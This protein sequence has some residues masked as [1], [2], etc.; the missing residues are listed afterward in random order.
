VA[1]IVDFPASGTQGWDEWERSIRKVSSERGLTN[2]VIS[3]ALP[4][5]KDHWKAICSEVDLEL[6]ERMIPGELTEEQSIAIQSL[7]D[8]AAAVVIDRLKQERALAVRRLALVEL[9]LSHSRAS[10]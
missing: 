5:I 4:R 9:A 2:E 6:P 8:D 3:H 1:Q 10:G 7:I